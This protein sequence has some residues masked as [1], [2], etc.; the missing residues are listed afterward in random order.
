M[1]QQVINV[2]TV[3]NDSTGDTI[4]ASFQKTNANFTELYSASQIA[5]NINVDT[6]GAIG[7]GVADDTGAFNAAITAANG[8]G[9][10]N[11]TSSKKYLLNSSI[12]LPSG[13]FIQG[14]VT[15]GEVSSTWNANS[16]RSRLVLGTGVTINFSS[17]S[18]I[19]GCS[20]LRNGISLNPVDQQACFVNQAAY[21]GTGL[22]ISSTSGAVV[23]DCVIIGFALGIFCS[24]SSRFHIYNT[25]GDCTAGIWVDEMHDIAELDTV[26]WSE[27]AGPASGNQ[28]PTFPITGAANNGSGLIRLTMASTTGLLTGNRMWVSGVTGT[29][30]AN[31]VWIGTVVD[32]THVD[33]QNSKFTNAYVSGGN[34]Y[35]DTTYRSGAAFSYSNSENL[36]F[37]NCFTYGYQIAYNVFSAGGWGNFVN[38]GCD[39]YAPR[40]DPTSIGIKIDGSN[41]TSWV[42]GFTSSVGTILEYN[43][44]PTN[45]GQGMFTGVSFNGGNVVPFRISGGRVLLSGCSTNTGGKFVIGNRIDGVWITGCDMRFVTINYGDLAVTTD[46]TQTDD[47]TRIYADCATT[48]N[49][50]TR[51]RMS[52]SN[53]NGTHIEMRT[54]PTADPH[55]LNQWWSNSG[56]ITI[57]AG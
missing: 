5:N 29:T 25:R 26:Q 53:F 44:N 24:H 19:L 54:L 39:A 12:T 30:E 3:A 56:V 52:N 51:S 7:D 38:C 36:R 14:D 49:P 23:R 46:S 21:S 18:G 37:V 9:I 33:L 48:T 15:A 55:I 22:T 13:V 40:N 32:S 11:I 27:M 4:R 2:G 43:G 41:F 57:S 31:N 50:K 34:L 10:I 42:G 8:N 1:T 6:Y 35:I 20:I 45:T 47:T 16:V 17:A 28:F